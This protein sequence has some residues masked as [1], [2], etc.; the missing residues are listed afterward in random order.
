MVNLFSRLNVISQSQHDAE[1][2]FSPLV[3]RRSVPFFGRPNVAT[4]PDDDPDSVGGSPARTDTSG[5]ISRRT[6]EE[7][8]E[9]QDQRQI[10]K[11]KKRVASKEAFRLDNISK[12]KCG[13]EVWTKDKDIA[14]LSKKPGP[15]GFRRT[16]VKTFGIIME[17]STKDDSF[18]L[19][20]FKNGKLMYCSQNILMFSS[21]IPQVLHLAKNKDNI[22]CV[23]ETYLS[24]EDKEEIMSLIL[25][26]KIYKL[27]GH[28]DCT[29]DDL[30]KT[31]KPRY[32]FISSW[33]MRNF[34]SKQRKKVKSSSNCT[35]DK[36]TI[37]SEDQF[38]KTKHVT[39]TTNNNANINIMSVDATSSATKDQLKICTPT[40]SHSLA[41]KILAKEIKEHREKNWNRYPYTM[42]P[43]LLPSDTVKASINRKNSTGEFVLKLYSLFYRF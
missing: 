28:D 1:L 42:Y 4:I 27:P 40:V 29:F 37:A 36:H 9:Y 38:Q 20:K 17:Q 33:K 8:E 6:G 43:C 41:K 23:K 24:Y 14:P 3:A 15:K 12:L 7:L 34:V 26:K 16:R 30:E 5:W 31:Y 35:T 13:V 11:I 22:L 10:E 39:T 19:V 2:D 21:C 18:W 25:Y 32:N